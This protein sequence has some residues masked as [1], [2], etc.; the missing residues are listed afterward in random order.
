MNKRRFFQGGRRKSLSMRLGSL[1][2]SLSLGMLLMGC[3]LPRGPEVQQP[4]A[5]QDAVGTA[6][7]QTLV[8]GTVS[9]EQTMAAA[10]QN[11]P[12]GAQPEAPTA[13]ATVTV[14]ISATSSQTPPPTLTWTPGAPM[15]SV[16]E[17]TNCRVGPGKVYELVGALLVGEQTEI[18]ARDP[19]GQYWYVRNPD[20]GGY[21]WLWGYYATTVG[22][23]G[24]LPVFTPPPTPTVTPTPTPVIAFN[25][26]FHEVDGCVGWNIEFELKNTGQVMFQ[27]VYTSVT[28]NNTAETVTS[29]S[30][31]FE[32]WN[33]CLAG[34]TY[35]D[36]DPGDIGYTVGGML[37]NDPTGHNVDATVKLCTG[38]GLAGTCVTRNLSFTP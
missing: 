7:Q 10:L 3:N 31:S 8:A 30:D 24:S 34:S 17:N 27:S 11:P 23:T 32:E 33:G 19:S 2:I 5:D 15:V 1:L 12:A 20:G 16:S 22:N 4:P 26:S 38:D 29:Q 9:A 37:A 28:D 13:T 25:A 36:L 18:V 6:V 14:E 35:L 21:C